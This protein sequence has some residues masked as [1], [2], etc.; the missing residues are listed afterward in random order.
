MKFWMRIVTCGFLVGH[1]VHAAQSAFQILGTLKTVDRVKSDRSDL[2]RGSVQTETREK[3]LE[4][5]IRRTNPT[6]GEN[7]VLEWVVVLEQ[8]NG[9]S[10]L[11]THGSQAIH[12]LV[13]VPVEV[14]SDTFTLWE[15]KF[16]GDGRVGNASREREV[17]GYAV[18]M[19]D[20]EG[21]ELAV[22]FQPKSVEED[23]R[24]AFAWAAS[25]KKEG[26]EAP[27]AKP[28][29]DGDRPERPRVPSRESRRRR[30]MLRQ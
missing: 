6:V 23:A 16:N 30:W 26:G 21:N 7:A 27:E 13:G 14:T 4:I 3:V 12:T 8:P 9:R 17:K 20:P 22:K 15:G 24:K 10:K 1:A 2:P 5:E 29:E 11:G 18:R 19:V 25:R 28:E